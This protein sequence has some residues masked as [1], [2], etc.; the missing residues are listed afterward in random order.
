MVVHGGRQENKRFEAA[1]YIQADAQSI[2][3]NPIPNN[4]RNQPAGLPRELISTSRRPEKVSW[5]L[6]PWLRLRMVQT[7][8]ELPRCALLYGWRH[9]RNTGLSEYHTYECGYGRSS[10]GTVSG[11]AV[12]GK[13]MWVLM[14]CYFWGVCP[15]LTHVI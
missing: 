12:P 4:T 8:S 13:P 7:G 3:R 11:C 5:G 9:G 15:P 6:V 14:Y 10:P 1:R 2:T